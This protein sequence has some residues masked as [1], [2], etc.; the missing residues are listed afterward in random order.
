MKSPTP[1]THIDLKERDWRDDFKEEF[2][3]HFSQSE[4][5]FAIAFIEELLEKRKR[6]ISAVFEKE[7]PPHGLSLEDGLWLK[8]IL[9]KAFNHKPKL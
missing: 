6:E 3:I 2:G 5:G 9:N 4:L 1:N 8:R 7:V